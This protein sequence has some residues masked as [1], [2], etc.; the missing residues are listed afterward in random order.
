MQKGAHASHLCTRELR[1][2]SLLCRRELMQVIYAEESSG[3]SFM[4][5]RAQVSHLC[6]RELRLVIYAEESSG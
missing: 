4:Q 1:Y 3:K 2:V 6:R 5:K